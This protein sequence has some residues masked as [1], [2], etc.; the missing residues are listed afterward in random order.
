MGDFSAF[1]RRHPLDVTRKPTTAGGFEAISVYAPAAGVIDETLE[2]PML[3]A[4]PL[5][6]TD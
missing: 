3:P 1:P 6:P 5:A 4:C 2:K